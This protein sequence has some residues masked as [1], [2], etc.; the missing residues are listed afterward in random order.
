VQRFRELGDGGW[1]PWRVVDPVSVS[2]LLL[3]LSHL[4]GR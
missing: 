4:N 1:L 2:E 3:E